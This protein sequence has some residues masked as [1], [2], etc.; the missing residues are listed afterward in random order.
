MSGGG[1]IRR[2][3]ESSWELRWHVAGEIETETVRGTRR[4]A[5]RRL[6]E[7]LDLADRG[8]AP[9][10]GTCSKWFDR[11]L[12][13]VRND[14]SPVTLRLYE[15]FVRRIFRPAFGDLKL[16]ELDRTTI[17]AAWA[18]LADRY[19]P[20]SV[21]V[22]HR[23]LSASLSYA[24][25]AGVL[26]SNPCAGW[27][28]GRGLPVEPDTETP[29]LDRAQVAAVIDAAR[30]TPLFAPVV[31]AAGL[32]SRRGEI[33]SLRWAD[34]GTNGRVSIKQAHRQLKADDIRVGP[35]KGKR[36]RQVMLP[37]SYLA[38]L[39]EWRRLQ[40]EQFLRLGRRPGANDYICTDEVGRMLKPDNLTDRYAKL[41]RGLGLPSTKIHSLRHTHASLLLDAGESVKAVQLR[42]GHASPSVTLNTYSHAIRLDDEAEAARLDDAMNRGRKR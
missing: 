40:A 36:I 30:G 21:R 12:H 1:H 3:G 11:W 32:G 33:T 39:N 5:Q 2:R 38:L 10:K 14:V 29:S 25:E 17:R 28:K 27:R 7:V 18:D 4:D 13:A 16:A 26:P 31:L 6:R 9:A 24:V 41:A 37:A 15:S 20:T 23:I 8:K 42:L 22:A 35:P 34:V 19:K